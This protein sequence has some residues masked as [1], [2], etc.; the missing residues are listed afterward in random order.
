MAMLNVWRRQ[1]KKSII[2]NIYINKLK[3]AYEKT[4]SSF[5]RIDAAVRYWLPGPGST[6][7]SGDG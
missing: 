4:F 1:K 3:R 7:A 2:I 6:C 5:G